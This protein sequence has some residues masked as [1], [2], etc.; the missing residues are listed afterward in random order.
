MN[1]SSGVS[2]RTA[3][4]DLQVTGR[5]RSLDGVRGIAVLLVLLAH[6]H[7]SGHSLPRAAEMGNIG[8]RLF[9]VLSGFL[10]T[11]LLQ[12]EEATK[13]FVSL[14]DFYM[15]RAFRILPACW[16]YVLVIAIMA[17]M[18]SCVI[19]RLALWASLAYVSN[20]V[21][22]D[23]IEQPLRHL[24]SLSVEEQFYVMWP[25]LFVYLPRFRRKIVFTVMVASP[26]WRIAI[27]AHPAWHIGETIDRRLDAIAD[28]IAVGCFIALRPPAAS[29]LRPIRAG[30]SLALLFTG[31]AGGFTLMHPRLYYGAG[32]TLLNCGLAIFV[33]AAVR[34]RVCACFRWL[35]SSPL[36]VMGTLSYSLYLW[37]QIVLMREGVASPP[38]W[39]QLCLCG[40]LAVLSF[41]LIEKPALRL[42]SALLNRDFR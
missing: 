30:L 10:I 38:L 2:D 9:F 17:A 8:V 22:W 28:C 42:R 29:L 36:V 21:R 1:L 18:H 35:E 40:V 16:F 14:K 27:V 13:G 24:W 19:S 32:E 11:S 33:A 37:Q 3:N 41:F 5:V 4:G 25:F 6:V 31:I 26:L 12:N 23:L 39:S 20:F 7:I 34:F 15:R